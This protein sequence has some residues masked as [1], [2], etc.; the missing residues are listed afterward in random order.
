[1]NQISSTLDVVQIEP[2]FLD[3]G[4]GEVLHAALASLRRRKLLVGTIVATALALGIIAVR[5]L[6]AWYT[7]EAY[8]RGGFAASDAVAKDEDSRS[9]LQISLD[10]MRV[11]DTQSLLLKSQEDLARRVVQQLGLEQLR[12]EMN[13]SHWLPEKFY[14]SGM[15]IKENETD[16]AATTLLRRLSVTRDSRAYFIEVQYTARDSALA[17]VIA[18]AFVAEFLRSSKLRTLSLQRSSAEATLSRQLAIFGVKHPRVIKAKMRLA[19]TDDL[20]KEQLSEAPEVILQTAGENVTKAIAARSSPKPPLVIGL[21]LLVGL[22]VGIAVALW[23]ERSR[24]AEAFSRY[25]A[26]SFA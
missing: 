10:L 14:N 13:E 24:Q 5:V 23:L 20:L 12:S 17:V 11:I 18:N 25:Y 19:A 21:L 8:I 22:V 4:F 6:P 2:S 3:V 26:R 15:S 1:M 16:H 9:A 7:A